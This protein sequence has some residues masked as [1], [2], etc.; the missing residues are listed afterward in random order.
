MTVSQAIKQYDTVNTA[1]PKAR[2]DAVSEHARPSN[3]RSLQGQLQSM[4]KQNC[5]YNSSFLATKLKP[6]V[7]KMINPSQ[8]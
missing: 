3:A 8:W 1:D 2:Q 5:Q 6:V 4:T 7:A